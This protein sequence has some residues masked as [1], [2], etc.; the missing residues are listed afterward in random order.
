[1]PKKNSLNKKF[2]LELIYSRGIVQRLRQR[3]NQIADEM[4]KDVKVSPFIR[5]KRYPSVGDILA[6]TNHSN[7]STEQSRLF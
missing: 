2:V 3:F 1:M 4:S 5:K 7:Q 6:V